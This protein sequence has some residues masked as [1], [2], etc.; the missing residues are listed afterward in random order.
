MSSEG[1]ELQEEAG[2][3]SRND[4]TIDWSESGVDDPTPDTA[5]LVLSSSSHS[6]FGCSQSRT[7]RAW[8]FREAKTS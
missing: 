2:R 1:H 5:V 8:Q 4:D 3:L 6:D 7:T